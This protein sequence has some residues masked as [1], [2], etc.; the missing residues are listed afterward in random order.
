MFFFFVISGQFYQAVIFYF[1]PLQKYFKKKLFA[2]KR[3]VITEHV[4]GLHIQQIAK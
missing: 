1:M 2:Q 4:I 3:L